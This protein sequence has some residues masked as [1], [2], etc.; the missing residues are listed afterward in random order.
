MSWVV[1]QI[2]TS[3]S[4]RAWAFGKNH[5]SETLKWK[6][7][8]LHCEQTTLHIQIPQ[9]LNKHFFSSSLFFHNLDDGQIVVLSIT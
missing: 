2:L 3:P 5:S 9:A 6:Y 8:V 4:V 1:G 7:V